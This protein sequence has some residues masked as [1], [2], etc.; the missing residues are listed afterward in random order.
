MRG[1]GIVDWVCCEVPAMNAIDLGMPA[2]PVREARIFEVDGVLILGGCRK[3]FGRRD[4][5]I[6]HLHCRG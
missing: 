6:H 5:L 2:T 1:S 3:V 4:A